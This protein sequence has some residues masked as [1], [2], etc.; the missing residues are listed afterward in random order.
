MVADKPNPVCDEVRK[1]FSKKDGLSKK[2][3]VALLRA[4]G[5]AYKATVIKQWLSGTKPPV[6]SAIPALCKII[7]LR[8]ADAAAVDLAYP[9]IE[10][11]SKE[12]VKPGQSKATGERQTAAAEPRLPNLL[13]HVSLAVRGRLEIEFP[14]QQG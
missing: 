9:D 1:A 10:W 2:D 11:W 4:E 6:R 5:V 13:H 3:A 14:G 8:Y 7:G 12:L